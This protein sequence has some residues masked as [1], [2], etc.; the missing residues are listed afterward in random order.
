[1]DQRPARGAAS[2]ATGSSVSP[3]VPTFRTSHAHY[4]LFRLLV[5]VTLSAEPAVRSVG[6]NLPSVFIVE[7]PCAA[8]P[9]P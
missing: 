5:D 4:G 6:W 9:W 8:V 7:E 2:R 3:N 1:M